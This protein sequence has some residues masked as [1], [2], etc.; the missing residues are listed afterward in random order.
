MIELV[1]VMV[2]VGI[3]A[4]AAIPRFVGLQSFSAR[5]FFDQTVTMLRYAQKVAIAQRRD[6]FVNID[7][8]TGNICLTYVADALCSNLASALINPA[9][10]KRFL[11]T[12]PAGGTFGTS[13]SFSFSALGRPSQNNALLLNPLL[14]TVSGDGVTNTITVERESGYVH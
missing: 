4:A 13:L 7:A 6:V 2:L 12:V 9:D 5:G 1:M 11:K 3:L 14:V 8:S 10:Q